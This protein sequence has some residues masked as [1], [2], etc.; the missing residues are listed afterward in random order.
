M[1]DKASAKDILQRLRKRKL[2]ATRKHVAVVGA[3]P[4]G[5]SA[6]FYLALLGHK[7]TVYE[8]EAEAGGMLRYALPEYRLPK[9]VLDSELQLIRGVGVKFQFN[10]ALGRNLALAKLGSDH[11]AVFLALGTWQELDL[12]VPGETLKG[13]HHALGFLKSVALSKDA[14]IGKQVVVVGGGNAAIDAAR[15]ALRLGAKVT[16]AYR[17]AKEDMPAIIEETEQALEEGA[18]LVCLA[19][20]VRVLGPKGTVTGL[21]VAKTVL[22]KFDSKGR[23]KPVVTD[24]K[25]TIP[26]DTI[27][28]AIGE[29]A[30]AGLMKKLGLELDKWGSI[31]VNPW[32][33]Q[34]SHPKVYAGG[35]LVTGAANVTSAMALGKKAAA[36]IDKQLMGADRFR[37]LWPKLKYDNSIP[38][39]SQGGPRNVAA[40]LPYEQRRRSFDE[41]S[42][43]FDEWPAKAEALRCLRCD[44]KAS[45]TAIAAEALQPVTGGQV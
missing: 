20:P 24:E 27:I 8:A 32:T 28:L 25:Y 16:I 36:T 30:D 41:V 17:R 23:R 7:V 42:R 1:L 2:A 13:V 33:L 14:K 5:L 22:G 34:S 11:D 4:A 26:C 10:K 3:G 19:A 35:D 43:T 31:H 37:H 40:V 9:A 12:R 18:N 6:A 38:P 45:N 29:K 39:D 15:T 44:V 21:E